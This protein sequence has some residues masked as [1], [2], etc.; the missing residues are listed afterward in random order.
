MA[1][2]PDN[3]DTDPNLC[4]T[5]AQEIYQTHLDITSALVL[6]GDTHTFA[7]DHIASVFIYRTGEGTTVVETVEDQNKDM[8]KVSQWLI[9]R[10]ATEYHRIA[11]Q[12]RFLSPNMIEG[13]HTTYAMHGA[14]NLTKPYHSRQLLRLEDGQW[15]TQMAEHEL[16]ACLFI[17]KTPTPMPGL[18]SGPWQL[19]RAAPTHSEADAIRIYADAIAQMDDDMNSDDFD[20]WTTRFALLAQMH[21]YDGDFNIQHPEDLRPFFTRIRNRMHELGATHIKRTATFAA[22]SEPGR[23][24]GYHD[25]VLLRDGAPC[26]TPVKS[27]QIYE[28]RDGQWLC[29]S[30]TNSMKAAF[31]SD[32]VLQPTPALPTIRQIEERMTK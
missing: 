1:Q 29:V 27:R 23:I 13:F 22:F 16:A 21:H 26:F 25:A 6:S 19:D 2:T 18:F 20:S 31:P 30:I 10:G 9:N 28:H 12:A 3:L 8:Q 7:R 32:T 11:R 14:V 17:N 15:R 4:D 24:L 5:R